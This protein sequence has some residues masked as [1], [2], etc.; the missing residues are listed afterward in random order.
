VEDLSMAESPGRWD[1]TERR[2]SPRLRKIIDDLQAGVRQ[3]HEAIAAISQEVSHLKEQI[4][5]LRR[6]AS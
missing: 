2:K 6:Q 4:D 1:G 5:R 3:N